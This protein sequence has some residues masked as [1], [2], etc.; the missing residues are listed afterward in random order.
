MP[1]GVYPRTKEMNKRMSLAQ[2]GYKHSKET[3]KKI[4]K[5]HKGKHHSQTTRFKISKAHIG[6]KHSKETKE[7]MSK[8]QKKRIKN[9]NWKGGKIRDSNGYILIYAH[10]HPFCNNKGYVKR[11]RLVME[12]IIGR[13]LTPE[14][15]VHHR[16][17]KYP[18]S[19]I[20]NKQDDR[21][22]NLQLF[23]NNKKHI[24]FHHLSN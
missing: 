17:I 16:G 5:S 10:N 22:E 15:V 20:E 21:P 18:I 7:K 19:S 13:Y 1:T 9:P 6:F 11:S 2:K 23:T 4:S 14:E 12:K 8:T 3:K 24:K